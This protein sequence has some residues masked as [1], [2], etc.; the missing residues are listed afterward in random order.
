MQSRTPPETAEKPPAGQVPSE[1]GNGE[2]GVDMQDSEPHK[3]TDEQVEKCVDEGVQDHRT[4]E[5]SETIKDTESHEPGTPM[6]WEEVP[7]SMQVPSSQQQEA[8]AKK[9]SAASDDPFEPWER[10]LMEELLN[11]VKGHLGLIP[12]CARENTPL[13]N[14]S[15][16]PYSFLRR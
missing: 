9:K 10:E 6:S 2:L 12:F 5:P 16:I 7:S 1:G 8:Q 4:S 15:T 11:D 3:M 13:M 14:L